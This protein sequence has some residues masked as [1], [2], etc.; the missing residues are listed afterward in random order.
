MI[1][2][3]DSVSRGLYFYGNPP[4]IA[5]MTDNNTDDDADAGGEKRLLVGLRQFEH[6]RLVRRLCRSPIRWPVRYG[7]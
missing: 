7:F 2:L 3:G 5:T 6:F 4:R 1:P